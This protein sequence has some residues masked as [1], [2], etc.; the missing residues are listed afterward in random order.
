MTTTTTRTWTIAIPAPIRMK[1]ANEREHHMVV[2]KDRRAWRE[3][4][5]GWTALA[6]LP[7]GLRRI[8]VD[9]ELRF[10]SAGRRDAHNYYS[11]V[12][13]PCID[14]LTPEKRVKTKTGY[15]VERGWGVIP[16]DTAEYLDLSAPRIGPVVPKG[17]HPYGLVVLTVTDLT[18]TEQP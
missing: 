11:A 6:K 8:H 12:V 17:A 3:T 9:V 18:E 15:R 1:S 7:R 13:K 14:A 5:Y 16:D 10:T 2:A 4:A